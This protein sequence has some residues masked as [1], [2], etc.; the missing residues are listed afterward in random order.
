M[1]NL[2]GDK[3]IKRF[4]AVVIAALVF[5]S[6][7]SAVQAISRTMGLDMLGIEADVTVGSPHS[8]STFEFPVPRMARIQAAS[9]AL[10]ITPNQQLNGDNIIFIYFNDE[11]VESRTVKDLRQQKN[12]NVKLK[13]VYERRKMN[14]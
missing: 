12:V 1:I 13:M 4:F 7:S 9:V 5:F 3:A 11:L 6:Y 10:T 8:S 2:E 14:G